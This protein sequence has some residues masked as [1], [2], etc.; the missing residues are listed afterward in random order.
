MAG[1]KKVSQRDETLVKVLERLSDDIRNQQLQLDDIVKQ[2]QDLFTEI[3][4]AGHQYHSRHDATNSAIER[5][6]DAF[7]RY[8]SDMLSLVHEQDHMNQVITDLGKKQ[9]VVAFSQDNIMNGLK[10]LEKRAEANDKI[11][12]EINTYSIR[13]DETLSREIAIMNRSVAKLH[14]DTEKHLGEMH[15]ET[16]KK[17][18]KMRM[19]VE[20][21]LLALD[22]IEAS[23]NVLLIR[24]EPPEKK[25][26]FVVRIIRRLRM[27]IKNI[28]IR[29]KEKS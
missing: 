17:L 28:W 3:E 20:R 5:S 4:R 24:T 11:V 12:R 13:H 10:S 23:L 8:R 16:H 7:Q 21:R 15:H 1:E 18:E 26:F 14:M 19:D 6:Q 29:L 22:K 27:L 25:P 2:Q 9:A